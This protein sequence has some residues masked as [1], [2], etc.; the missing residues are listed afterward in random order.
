MEYI[1]TLLKCGLLNQGKVCVPNRS[2]SSTE[3]FWEIFSVEFVSL[4]SKEGL[5]II[6]D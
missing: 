6:T 1:Y 4:S 3:S 5:K 2:P